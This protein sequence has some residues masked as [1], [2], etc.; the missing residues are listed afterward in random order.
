MIKTHVSSMLKAQI[1]FHGEK[2]F[3]NDLKG[4]FQTQIDP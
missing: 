2:N 3:D 4:I 1:A